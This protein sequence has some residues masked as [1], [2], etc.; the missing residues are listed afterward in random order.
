MNNLFGLPYSYLLN[1]VTY[2][3]RGEFVIYLNNDEK[4][5]FQ[6]LLDICPPYEIEQIPGTSE[7][8]TVLIFRFSVFD[9]ESSRIEEWTLYR[10]FDASES[11]AFVQTVSQLQ[12]QYGELIP[13]GIPGWMMLLPKEG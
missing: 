7:T 6:S 9:Q 13:S 4:T 8:C 2:Y 3:G 1:G 10:L 11:P 5:V 12:E